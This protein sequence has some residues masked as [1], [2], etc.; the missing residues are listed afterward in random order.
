VHKIVSYIRTKNSN[1]YIIS[2]NN[3]T[4]IKDEYNDA[5]EEQ[6]KNLQKYKQN[7]L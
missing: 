6:D 7:L 2:N 1:T 4:N 3:I 5:N